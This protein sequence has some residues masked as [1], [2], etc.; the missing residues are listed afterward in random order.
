MSSSPERRTR[1][2]ARP[3]VTRDTQ[4][5]LQCAACDRKYRVPPGRSLSEIEC[6][7]CGSSPLARD[8]SR[9]AD[10]LDP[11]AGPSRY[12][13]LKRPST[14]R[15]LGIVDFASGFTLLV[16]IVAGVWYVAT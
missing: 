4:R 8:R 3:A 16:G 9:P 15:D 11:G 12:E 14:S 2:E 7:H 5:V 10:A 1:P 13:L 6:P